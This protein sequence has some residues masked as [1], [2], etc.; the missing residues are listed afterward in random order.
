M[1]GLPTHSSPPLAERDRFII[2]GHRR[3]GK[4]V[5]LARLYE[6]LWNGCVILGDEVR[7]RGTPV[8]AGIEAASMSCHADTGPMHI[9]LMKVIDELGSGRWPS[10]TLGTSHGNL[11]VTRNGRK[12]E[13]RTFDYPGEVF[14]RAFMEDSDDTDALQLRENID[15]AAGVVML[16]DPGLELQSKEDAREDSFGLFLAA[17]R[18][19]QS[20]GGS[21]VPIA[22]VMTKCDD[23]LNRMLVTEAGGAVAFA[24]RRFPQLLE[25]LGRVR[26][27]AANAVRTRKDALGKV[28]PSVRK[29]PSFIVQPIHDCLRD[30][31][32]LERAGDAPPPVPEPPPNWLPGNRSG[33]GKWLGL[34]MPG[35]FGLLSLI[36]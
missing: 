3:A 31:E 23:S 25:T 30:L 10:A 2:L 22:L 6:A 26:I 11:I 32:R 19:R 4:T 16:V 34:V 8:P 1:S 14:R 36:H 27:Y 7:P 15:R 29:P 13:M 5:F 9:L 33:L 24:S 21:D 20:P 12:R 18:I 35:A 17:R 28:I